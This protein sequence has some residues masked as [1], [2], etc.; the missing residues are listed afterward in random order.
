[1][2]DQNLTDDSTRPDGT[3]D[4]EA[5]S[6]SRGMEQM[7]SSI[8]YS[9]DPD[10]IPCEDVI[11]GFQMG[12]VGSLIAPGGTGKSFL[13]M[14]LA[15]AV[16]CLRADIADFHPP[17]AGQV[18]YVNAEDGYFPLAKRMAFIGQRI[19]PELRM[20]IANNLCVVRA[21]GRLIDLGK[22]PLSVDLD[23]KFRALDED[24]ILDESDVEALARCFQDY[25]LII[26][27]TL[28]R[29][30]ML[31]ENSNSQM[32]QLVSMLEYLAE[33][34]GAAVLFLHHANKASIRDGSTDSQAAGRGASVLTDNVRWASFLASMTTAEAKEL[35]VAPAN[36][37]RYVRFGVS[38]VNHGFRPE[39]RWF[40]RK[41]G[42]VLVPVELAAPKSQPKPQP[43][44]KP[45]KENTDHDQLAKFNF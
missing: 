30:H 26:F 23:T 16:A 22:R 7:R 32:S 14:E 19:A 39:D 44:P 25:R 33:S 40:E 13:A 24:G 37:G 34:T 38:K 20:E 12:S 17:K 31:D 4:L 10:K 5:R 2:I 21:R 43:G 18:A 6:L 8:W 42:G 28:N 11:Q 35:G 41:A 15:T 3:L 36:R 9:I 29:F 45:K 27:D 1:M